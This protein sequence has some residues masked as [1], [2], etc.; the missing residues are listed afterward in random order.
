MTTELTIELSDR[1]VKAL[2]RLERLG[3]DC[4]SRDDLTD[5]SRLS[6]R[7]LSDILSQLPDPD[8][9]LIDAMLD[10]Y[11]PGESARSTLYAKYDGWG[12]TLRWSMRRVLE[13]VRE[14]DAS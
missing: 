13:L 11:Y 7:V 9:E 6:I 14:R 3:E 12:D 2:R 1:D 4:L 8:E 10:A 5:L